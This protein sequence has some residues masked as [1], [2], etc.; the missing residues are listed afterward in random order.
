M[1][2]I[3]QKASQNSATVKLNILQNIKQLYSF[4]AKNCFPLLVAFRKLENDKLF[5]ISVDNGMLRR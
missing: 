2:K 3:R 5:I 1:S 4:K